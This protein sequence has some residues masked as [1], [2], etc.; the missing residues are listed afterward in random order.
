MKPTR[1]WV[2]ALLGLLVLAFALRTHDLE[3]QSMWSDEGLSLY[4]AQQPLA[5][6]F[7]NQIV[8]DGVATTDTNPP[9]YF[10]LLHG[11]RALV[12]ESVFLLR[13]P[14]AVLA[15]LAVPLI[16]AIGRLL[17]GR[18]LGFAAALLLALS[19]FHVW[20][21]QVM[22]NYGLLL[23]LNLAS[24][25]AL[26]RFICG[27]HRWSWLALWLLFALLGIYTHFFGFFVFAFGLLVLAAALFFAEGRRLLRLK[28]FWLALALGLLLALPIFPLALDRF[29][30]GQQI[31]FFHV[32]V[33]DILYHALSAYGTGVS[34]TITQSWWRWL[35]AALLV[36]I[37]LALAWRRSRPAFWLLLSYQ[38]VPLALLILVSLLNPLYNGV[39]HLLIGLPPFLLL[40]AWGMVGGR[41]LVRRAG[42]SLGALFLVIQT[43]WLWHQFNA[44]E[45]VRDDVRAA[46]YYL[47][48]V[49]RPDD[50]VVLH[51]TLISFTFD[52]YYA[53]AAPVVAVPGYGAT[54][55]QAALQR[56]QQVTAGTNRVWFL[57]Q[58]APRTGFDRSLLRDWAR[59]NW[60][61]IDARSF[62]WMWLPVRLEAYIA[63]PYLRE[64]PPQATV[65]EAHWPGVLRLHGYQLPGELTSGSTWWPTF[66]L[67]QDGAGPRQY[68][69]SL[70]L[71]AGGKT[72]DFAEHV[73][74]GALRP[75]GSWPADALVR[76]V[77]P[78]PLPAGHPQGDYQLWLRVVETETGRLVPLA[79]GSTELSLGT[80][81]LAAASCDAAAN[82]W[83]V[84]QV[85]PVAFGDS[86]EL[87]GYTLPAADYRPGHRLGLDLLWCLR[88][89]P[90]P[91]DAV[92]LQLVDRSGGVVAEGRTS[93][94]ETPSSRSANHLLLLPSEL[95]VPAAAEPGRYGVRV[96]LLQAG[97]EKPRWIYLPWPARALTLGQV[98][99]VAWPLQTTLPPIANQLEAA[100]GA[101]PLVKL[102]GY[103]LE[104][105]AWQPGEALPFTLVWRSLAG[106]DRNWDVLVHLV[107]ATGEIV[108]QGDGPPLHGF[109]PTASWRAGEVLVDERSLLL[110]DSLPPGRYELWTGLYDPDTW[111]R[112]PALLDGQRLPGDRLL[113]ATLELEAAGD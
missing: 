105:R 3:G 7:A 87:T 48:E 95:T 26:F 83:P 107:D 70:R 34:P 103:D 25:Y 32:P 62:P 61:E 63:A 18:S 56:L 73:L 41:G 13:F 2:V 9:V 1:V 47:N 69:L 78:M 65:H 66:F 17:G 72:W 20:Q 89:Q 31:D 109:R 91:G 106:L 59:N 5:A 27:A 90:E 21:A 22:R 46:A 85:Q 50:V 4:R 12:G 58:P 33:L 16:Y 11:W 45:L 112:L 81:H 52:H 6:L 64:M 88:R 97:A 55:E 102:Y 77:A 43:G 30:A 36:L 53:G 74:G 104:E 37:G 79:G 14:G 8:V 24:I 10:L 68:S 76:V 54:D 49:A 80:H 86:L 40:A 92:I 57:V 71:E 51:D 84:A 98:D 113:L 82:T 111:E 101:P 110:P 23:T 60:L 28:W 42:L 38:V 108:A 15:A 19:P 75:P 29:R 44:P 67:V 96:S 100:F 35:P 39:R 93:L 94:G 99:V